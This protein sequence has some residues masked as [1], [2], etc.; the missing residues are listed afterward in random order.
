[1]FYRLEA[2]KRALESGENE[3]LGILQ[4]KEVALTTLEQQCRKL[5]MQEEQLEGKVEQLQDDTAL[6]RELL[7]VGYLCSTKMCQVQ[8]WP[9]MCKLLLPWQYHIHTRMLGRSEATWC[10]P[11]P[12]ATMHQPFDTYFHY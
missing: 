9:T 3:M 7:Q 10:V 12:L 11:E 4:E 8:S 5:G 6:Y 2:H 1:M